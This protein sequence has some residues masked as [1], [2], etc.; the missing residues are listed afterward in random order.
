MVKTERSLIGHRWIGGM[1]IGLD[2]CGIVGLHVA[3]K[4]KFPVRRAKKSGILLSSSSDYLSCQVFSAQENIEIPMIKLDIVCSNTHA[5]SKQDSFKTSRWPAF[6]F[7]ETFTRD[8][9]KEP[10]FADFFGSHYCIYFTVCTRGLV[11]THCLIPEGPD[12]WFFTSRIMHKIH[13]IIHNWSNLILL[14]E[15]R[16]FGRQRGNP[17][18][19]NMKRSKQVKV[20][21]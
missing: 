3:S 13:F 5:T 20:H 18:I 10:A 7:H 1:K 2:Q 12:E 15:C 17:T 16:A 4:Y 19:W 14:K 6:T 8:C 21:G 11:Y 9:Q